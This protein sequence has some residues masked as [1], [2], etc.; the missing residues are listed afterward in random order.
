M[1]F[2]DFLTSVFTNY[3]LRNVTIGAAIMG[4]VS[5]VLGSFALLRKQSLMGDAMSHAALP[6]IA[7]IFILTQLKTP[8]ALFA[9]AFVSA[10]LG[11]LLVMVTRRYTRVKEDSGLGVVLAVFFGLG[12][13]LLSWI[14]RNMGANQAGLDKFLFGRAAAMVLAVVL[15][16]PL[17]LAQTQPRPGGE[18][19]F[20]TTE[21]PDTLDPQKT[22]AAVT[23]NV[24]RWIGDTL[25]TK[26]MSGNYIGGLAKSWTVSRDGLVWTFQLKENVKFH[27]GNALNAQ[28]VKGSI[29]R[30]LAPETKSP[31]AGALGRKALKPAGNAAVS[32]P[33]SDCSRCASFVASRLSDRISRPRYPRTSGPP[34]DR[35]DEADEART[36]A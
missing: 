24:M 26:D 31:V 25:I 11:A 16:A 19:V 4:T 22:S 12:L 1:D 36:P 23:G 20:V 33:R 21:E 32:F 9:G 18:L 13:V 14:Q 3:T 6:G 27:D 2:L 34:N 29:D 30:A 28:A 5:G 8:L 7:L 10:W 35:S 15:L 17:A